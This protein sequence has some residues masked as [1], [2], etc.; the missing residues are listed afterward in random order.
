MLYSH[1]DEIGL[2]GLE[3]YF[4]SVRFIFSSPVCESCI[5]IAPL[6]TPLPLSH[7]QDTTII[8]S[9]YFLCVAGFRIK[10]KITEF[11]DI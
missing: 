3:C 1:A 7:P 11:P 6:F 9:F 5:L 4:I 8:R 10:C 2:S